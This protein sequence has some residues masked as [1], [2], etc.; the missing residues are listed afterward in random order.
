[1]KH[2]PTSLSLTLAL[3]FMVL[4]SGC[5]IVKK[6]GVDAR[7]DIITSDYINPDDYGESRPLNITLF[8]LTD[9]SEFLKADYYDLFQAEKN[10][11]AGTL[12]SKSNVLVLPND[13]KI[14]TEEVS[15]QVGAI[16]V[17]YQF[18]QLEESQWLALIPTPET[19]FFGINC[20]SILHNSKI[21][22]SIDELDT[23]TKLVD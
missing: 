14:H 13:H 8:Y 11:L 12:I 16:G 18:R 9:S 6:P 22:I 21:F 15:K 7:F 17:A 5:T 23:K 10:P 2:I 20:K 4:F 1:M 3:F 19:C